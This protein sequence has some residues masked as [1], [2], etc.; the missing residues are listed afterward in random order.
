MKIAEM[1]SRLTEISEELE[2]LNPEELTDEQSARFDELTEEST[3]L[4]EKIEKAEARQEARQRVAEVAAKSGPSGQERG[5]EVPNVNTRVGD[6]PFDV[7]DLRYGTP[8]SEV[9]SRAESA[10]EKTVGDLDDEMRESAI[11]VMRT[12]KHDDGTG[13]VARRI[14]A[15]GTPEYRTA[16]QKMAGGQAM[17][18]T[19]EERQAVSRA[20]SLTGNA[21]GFAIPFTL[22]PTII[23]TGDGAANPFRQV[24][25]VEQI[26]TDQW[27]GVSSAGVSGGYAAEASEVGDDSATLAQPSI[28]VERWDVF[29]PFSFEVGQDWV[30]MESDVRGLVDQKR[31]EFDTVAFTSGSGSDEPT[32]ITTALDGTGSEIAP[33]TAET[34]AVADLYKV[35]NALPPHYRMTAQQAKW[36]GAKGTANDIRQ[37]DTSGGTDLWVRLAAGTPAELIGYEFYEN[38]ALDATSDINTGATADNFVLV[39][40]DWRNYK[41]VDRV[42]LNWELVP[43]LFATGNNRPSG[44]RGFLAWGRTG[45]DSVNDNAF[46]ML[47]IPTT[48]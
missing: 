25:D 1:R 14:L 26:A 15:T 13:I 41:I 48:A 29:I 18:L 28:D 5:F 33:T 30:N 23:Y 44:Q 3:G 22:D 11:R 4:V 46:A 40:G 17:L 2:A 24:C 43:H 38:S 34:F 42:G 21:G 32:G 6:D 37:F 16:F 20:Q 7:S 9:R 47:S 39:L 45:A 31:F 19:N 10:I 36:M 27:N 8:V 35:E 12:A